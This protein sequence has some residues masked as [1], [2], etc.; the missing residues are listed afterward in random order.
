M[1]RKKKAPA[2]KPSPTRNPAAAASQKTRSGQRERTSAENASKRSRLL[3]GGIA[4]GRW[5]WATVTALILAAML[6]EPT[7]LWCLSVGLWMVAETEFIGL[8]MIAAG[9]V[10]ACVPWAFGLVIGTG[11]FWKSLTHSLWIGLVYAVLGF[12]FLD[13]ILGVFT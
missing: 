7:M 8:W 2:K 12:V 13:R 6:F 11:R 3:R 1:S 4:W 5:L 9:Y 10:L